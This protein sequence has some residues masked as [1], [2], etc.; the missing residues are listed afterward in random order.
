M[1]ISVI[2]GLLASIAAMIPAGIAAHSSS[3][4]SPVW[5]LGAAI[6]AVL[7][8]RFVIDRGR[9]GRAYDGMADLLIHIHSP[10]SPDSGLR[11]AA[12]GLISALFAASGAPVGCE[13]PAIEFG[14]AF[15]VAT[16]S[17]YSRWFE[18][19]RRSDAS[20]ALAA[21]V[22]AGLGAPF[23]GFVLP[24]EL[25][26][27]G[28]HVDVLVASFA[29]F[30]GSRLI[31][32]YFD[33]SLPDFGLLLGSGFGTGIPAWNAWVAAVAVGLAAGVVGTVLIRFF[34]YAQES[35]MDLFQ[36]QTWMRTLGAGVL[37]FL[38]LL[39]FH[40]GH[41]AP[42]LIFVRML[43][44][45]GSAVDSAL[46]FGSLTLSFSMMLAG[47][48]TLGVF[49]PLAALGACLGSGVNLLTLGAFSAPAAMAGFAGVAGLWGAV[50]GTPLA[51]AV[52]AFE[53]TGNA[54][55]LLP[56]ILAGFLGREVR[57]RLKT[58]TLAELDLESRG[59]TLMEGR[60]K[61]VLDSVSVA[62]AMVSDHEVVH[63]L[64][65]VADIYPRLRKSRY[66][67]LPVVSSSNA[68]VGLL[69]IDLVQD[70]W[71]AQS[72]TSNSSLA[73]LLEAK[74]LLYRAGLKAPTVKANERLTA[75]SGIFGAMPCAVVLTDEGRVSGLL[76]AHNVRLAYD[77][78]VGRRSLRVE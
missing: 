16:R 4:R 5:V 44:G 58:R 59:L 32:A 22:A 57:R 74:D 67:F 25:G 46:L 1:L 28:R 43:Q 7:I 75:T 50:L 14:H 17:K 24:L 55:V 48:G 47:F 45:Q 6:A 49:A 31:R 64:E 72:A 61:A 54:P 37:L 73:K 8:Q 3:S 10:S 29:A 13:G 52:L 66:P 35:L 65:P 20:R 78:E 41:V 51:G 76:F 56:C 34:R 38:V 19:Q 39:V 40:P 53:L 27:G 70:A 33:F 30:L 21:G 18:R 60:S 63:E 11:W 9:G 15:A 26:M 68:Y 42:S 71:R 77:R 36:T 62:D 69:T 2:A 12:R 23:A